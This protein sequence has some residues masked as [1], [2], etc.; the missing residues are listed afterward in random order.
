MAYFGCIKKSASP[1]TPPEP[2]CLYK[3][4]FTKS[5]VDEIQNYEVTLGGGAVRTNNGVEFTE[6]RH[7]INFTL[8]SWD[9]LLNKTIELDIAKFDFKGNSNYDL[10]F[11]VSATSNSSATCY[12]AW[13]ANMGWK[14]YGRTVP[15]RTGGYVKESSLFSSELGINAFDGK[16]L[17]LKIIRPTSGYDLFE[18]YLNNVLVGQVNDVYAPVYEGY[19]NFSIGS[20]NQNYA[21]NGDQCYDVIISGFRVYQ[22]EEV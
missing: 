10:N 2:I 22:N 1:P 12:L 7:R 4:D 6:R 8:P 20:R 9:F 5:L 16:T 21:S 11:I 18:L 13:F 15:N 14:V 3:W 19:T 17:K